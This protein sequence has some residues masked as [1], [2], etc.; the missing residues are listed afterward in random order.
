RPVT[1]LRNPLRLR[2]VDAAGDRGRQARQCRSHSAQEIAAAAAVAM[3]DIG[4]LPA[5]DLQEPPCK[6]EIEIA[7]GGDVIDLCAGLTRSQVDLGV[8]GADEHV[9][10]LFAAQPVQQVDDLLRASVE[11]PA[12]F[13][14]QYFH[15][16]PST[17]R[18]SE[19][20]MRR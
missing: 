3:Y 5:H 1:K 15:C 14:V 13:D 9:V 8:R 20:S 17:P 6:A 7:G 11:V 18:K 2:M 12:R 19:A 16:C 4:L 10:N